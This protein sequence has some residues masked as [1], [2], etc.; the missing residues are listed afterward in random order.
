[1]NKYYVELF[2]DI[3]SK[4]DRIQNKVFNSCDAAIKYTLVNCGLPDEE[5]DRIL[6]WE[7]SD[8]KKVVWQFS[9]WH[10]DYDEFPGANTNPP[11]SDKSLS[12]MYYDAEM[13][14][15][16]YREIG[17]LM[18]SYG[19]LSYCKECGEE[20]C[21]E[22]DHLVCMNEDCKSYRGEEIEEDDTNHVFGLKIPEQGEK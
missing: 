8:E 11:N 5:D 7:V 14:E 2:G 16:G 15:E 1:M 19:S 6:V 21:Q 13:S 18:R 20:L 12:Q 17:K 22:G 9:G 3:A 10:F 4:K